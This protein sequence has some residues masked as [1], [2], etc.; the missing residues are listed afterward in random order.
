MNLRRIGV[1]FG[2]E[3][4]GGPK[5]FMFTFAIVI[6]VIMSLVLSL[7]FGTIFSGKPRLG[8]VD[9]GESKIVS[10]AHAMKSLIV[11][12][13]ETE[14]ALKEATEHG[15]V[16]V[17]MIL[18]DNF[19]DNLVRGEV[20][21]VSVYVWGESL[22]KDR[23]SL[24]VAITSLLRDISGQ[25]S[26]IE[27][28]TA[29]VNDEESIPWED[30]LLP[31][32]VMISM[33]LG[34]FMI[35]SL[36]VVQEKTQKTL[37]AISTTPASYGEI[38]A[39]KGLLGVLLSLAMG[40]VVL[41]MNTA[42]G[43][44]PG[45]LIMVLVLAAIAASLFGLIMGALTKD[46]NTLFATIKGL[47]IFLYAPAIVYMFP[48]IPQWIGYIF[49]TYYMLNPVIKISLEDGGWPDIALEVFVLI[50]MIAVL[51]GILSVV[52]NRLRLK[53]V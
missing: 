38:F 25:E 39:A 32:V 10:G 17:G 28:T 1:L 53:E 50:G 52:S 9:H 8:F 46:I 6:P 36:S 44:R 35:P 51:I 12:D 15:A 43:S 11:K 30:R 37:T 20:A 34:G 13:Y 23:A 19:D 14:E 18:A 29:L 3:L 48:K 40:I 49:P 24:I 16:D 33:L 26:P 41:V 45:L 22:L 21:E 42:F 4:A 7:L 47:G 2:K 5:N 27:V 31:F